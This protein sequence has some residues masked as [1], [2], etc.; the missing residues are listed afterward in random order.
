MRRLH[1]RCV[2]RGWYEV[3]G[4]VPPPGGVRHG[5][6]MTLSVVRV[7]HTHMRC[8]AVAGCA[9]RSLR[10]VIHRIYLSLLLLLR[11]T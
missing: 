5:P 10:P 6:N 8:A 3:S 2:I 11:V 4:R 9:C 1:G 7:R